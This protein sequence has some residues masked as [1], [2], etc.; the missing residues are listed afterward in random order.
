M[1]PG[2]AIME[3]LYHQYR[4]F[5]HRN[6]MVSQSSYAHP[7]LV[8][9]N[10]CVESGTINH[11]L[12]ITL[13][14]HQMEHFPRHWPFVRGIHRWSLDSP[15]KGEWR[16][17]LMFSLICAWTNG[18]TN[19]WDASDLT[20]HRTH[21]YVTVMHWYEIGVKAS[22]CISHFNVAAC[23]VLASLSKFC[24]FKNKSHTIQTKTL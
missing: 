19:N 7:L 14:R 21:Y 17:A 15:Y 22:N 23:F 10:F 6:K 18:W 8:R 13:W 1:A 24:I 5:H 2:N 3:I 11:N 4:H 16:R 9:W 20:R 12:S